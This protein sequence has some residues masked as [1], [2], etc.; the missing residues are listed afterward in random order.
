MIKRMLYIDTFTHLRIPKEETGMSS[1]IWLDSLGYERNGSMHVYILERRNIGWKKIFIDKTSKTIS[2][3]I[4]IWIG[5]NRDVIIMHWM[6][7]LADVEVLNRFT[8]I[9]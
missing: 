7:K 2:P 4:Q 6:K 5:K 1:D 9:L 3:E 8:N